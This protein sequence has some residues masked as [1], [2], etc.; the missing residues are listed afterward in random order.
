M[1]TLCTFFKIEI[2]L[3]IT[4]R[5]VKSFQKIREPEKD[6]ENSRRKTYIELLLNDANLNVLSKISSCLVCFYYHDVGNTLGMQLV[7]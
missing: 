4:A 7:P 6:V 2:Q 3:Q 1:I 5:A